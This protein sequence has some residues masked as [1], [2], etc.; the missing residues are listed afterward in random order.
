MYGK[1]LGVDLSVDSYELFLDEIRPNWD[2]AKV[3]ELSVLAIAPVVRLRY[4]L[5]GGRL[6]PYFLAGGGA[7]IEE[8]NDRTA[9]TQLPGNTGRKVRGFGGGI[10]Y[11]FA[12]NAAVGLEGRYFV[13]GSHGYD[14]D[15][16]PGAWTSTWALPR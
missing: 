8:V 3:A 15:G 7:A 4:P 6:E 10:D 9:D 12:E 11:F 14:T 1:Y 2:P 5:L 16:S 13:M